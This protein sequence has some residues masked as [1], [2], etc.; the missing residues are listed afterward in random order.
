[1]SKTETERPISGITSRSE[2][3][4]PHPNPCQQTVPL[5]PEEKS[6]RLSLQPASTPFSLPQAP[7]F[8]IYVLL[9]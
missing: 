3:Q 2:I 5:T 8:L 7:S 4:L 9:I 1:M 6:Y